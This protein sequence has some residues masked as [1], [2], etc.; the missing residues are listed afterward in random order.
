MERFSSLD[1]LLS[2]SWNL[3]FRA[4]AGKNKAFRCGYV[5]TIHEGI[6][7][8]RTVVLR[9]VE[10]SE[11]ELVFYTDH[12]SAKVE[13]LRRNPHLS[14]LFWDQGRSFQ[15]RASG[16]T[17]L[18]Y[19]DDRAR[20]DWEGLAPKDRKD[21]GAMQ[22]PG[23]SLPEPT[24]G[25]PDLW[26]EDITASQTEYTFDNFLL[27]S[28]FVEDLDLLHLHREG[29]QRAQFSWEEEEWKGSWVVP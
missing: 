18:H 2:H 19:R 6:P 24:D 9:K 1:S 17:Q 10:R 5:G 27:V 13:Q 26:D 21:Y 12:R 25:K 29:H 4:T 22:A 3:L 28:T 20:K 8:L 16:K 7:Q 11:R 15:L 23:T 14:W